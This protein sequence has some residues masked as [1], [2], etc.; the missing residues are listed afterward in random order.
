VKSNTTARNWQ[1]GV[2][3]KTWKMGY[4]YAVA[5]TELKRIAWVVEDVSEEIQGTDD[6]NGRDN[7]TPR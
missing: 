3:R 4:P 2:V 6:V 7:K 1:H 5:L